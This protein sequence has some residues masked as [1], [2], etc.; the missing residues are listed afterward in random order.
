MARSLPAEGEGLTEDYEVDGAVLPGG[1]TAFWGLSAANRD[2]RTSADPDAMGLTRSPNP[3]AQA[4]EPRPGRTGHAAA[5][6]RR[7][8]RR[9]PARGAGAMVTRPA[10]A[11]VPTVRTGNAGRPTGRE[12]P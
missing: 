3:A 8:H 4:A 7:A 10:E 11:S 2:E 9:W 12:R 6:D 5:A 1:T